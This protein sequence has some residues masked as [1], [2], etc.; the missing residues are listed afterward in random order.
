MKREKNISIS[1][2]QILISSIEELEVKNFHPDGTI[3]V[4][5]GPRFS[6]MAESKVWQSYKASVVGMTMVPEVFIILDNHFP[7]CT[8]I[9][10]GI[11]FK[12][13]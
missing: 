13:V 6:T 9:I 1:S 11:L 2:V 4:I 8:V 12:N 3:V 5:E 10:I 7:T